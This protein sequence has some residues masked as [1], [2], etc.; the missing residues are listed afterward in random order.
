MTLIGTAIGGSGS[1]IAYIWDYEGDGEYD[2]SSTTTGTTSHIYDTAGS[3]SP[4]VMVVDSNG[5]TDTD[6]ASLTVSSPSSLKVWISQPKN[7]KKVWGSDVT[8]YA[9]TAP[10]SITAS[11][12]FQY[13]V[14]D[15]DVTEWT[16]IGSEI[17]PPPDSFFSTTWDVTG[18]TEGTYDLQAVGTDTSDNTV[19]SESITVT[20][21]QTDPD[22]RDGEDSNGDRQKKEKI[23]KDETVES[24][25]E[26]YTSV[27]IPYG[28]LPADD[29][30]TTT[31]SQ[32]NPQGTTE[33]AN[34]SL[35]NF[36]S[37]ELEGDPT[38]LKS[39][40]VTI[41]YDDA[42]N[43]EIVD[44]TNIPEEDLKLWWYNTETG[45]WEKIPDTEIDTTKKQVK[46]E[47]G[48]LSDFAV[49]SE[50]TTAPSAPS[51]LSA[52]AGDGQVSLSWTNPTDTDFA[53][54]KVIRKTGGYPSS[55]TDGTEVYSGIGTSVTDTGRTNG[56]TYYYSVFTYDEVPNYS[57]AGE[58]S[59][60]PQAA[61]T[62]GGGGGGGCFVA[63]AVYGTPMAEE[64]VSLCK[65]RD[66]YLLTNPAGKN[67]IAFYYKIGPRLADF[68]SRHE[69]LKPIVRFILRPMVKLVE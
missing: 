60:T 36:R 38:L 43:D 55:V 39:V 11:V 51:G 29:V 50:D 42:D 35:T 12:K 2:W 67:L 6:S 28:S 40:T 47:M 49:G 61:S 14:S 31:I 46:A 7:G 9:N 20:V 69:S 22:V 58:T 27:E 68:I 15:P 25:M 8:L 18:L 66:E 48:H 3:Y 24:S 26:D 53:G 63:T 59:A 56:T 4:T 45:E 62:G 16:D 52:T 32:T 57:S 34:T 33:G 44:G 37:I 64:V 17:F 10:G 21:T 19:N 41:P 13:K 23:S 65:F 30:L 54:V 1:Y 5:L